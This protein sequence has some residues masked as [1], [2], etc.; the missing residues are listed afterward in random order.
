MIEPQERASGVNH[1]NMKKEEEETRQVLEDVF[2]ILRL[3]FKAIFNRLCVITLWVIYAR[4]QRLTFL[5]H[6]AHLAA[7]VRPMVRF[8]QN[9]QSR[10]HHQLISP[11]SDS[12]SADQSADL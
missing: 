2:N 3:S 8:R 12:S 1:H 11:Q 10:T 6:S 7:N 9:P 4:E 5:Q